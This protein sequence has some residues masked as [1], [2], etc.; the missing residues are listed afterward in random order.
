[1]AEISLALSAA[2]DY[3]ALDNSV[4]LEV[5]KAF[6][7]LKRDPR[8][9]GDPL[10]NKAGIDLF[11]FYSIRAGK[12]VRVIYTV[13]EGPH[14]IVRVIGLRERFSAHKAARERIASLGEMVREEL[15][16][17]NKLLEDGHDAG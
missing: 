17:L 8:G 10:G 13:E 9:Y 3:L 7:K 12:R 14:V 2:S 6:E 1:M 15:I 11:G 16:A 5:R 4:R